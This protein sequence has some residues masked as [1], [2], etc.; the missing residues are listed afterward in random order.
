MSSVARLGA[1]KIDATFCYN[2]RNL[3]SK[4]SSRR[5]FRSMSASQYGDSF[6]FAVKA[7]V[8]IQEKVVLVDR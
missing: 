3:F 7:S 1:P 2:Q 5:Q 8:E 4:E 6:S